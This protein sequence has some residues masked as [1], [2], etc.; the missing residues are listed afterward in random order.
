[1]VDL[2][3]TLTDGDTSIVCSQHHGI[4]TQASSRDQQVVH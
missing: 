4:I 1:V 2:S 3:T